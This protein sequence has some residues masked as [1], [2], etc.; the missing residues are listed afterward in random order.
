MSDLNPTANIVFPSMKVRSCHILSSRPLVDGDECGVSRSGSSSP[1]VIG[2][3]NRRKSFNIMS[4][5]DIGASH[6]NLS[7][8]NCTYM[9][10]MLNYPSLSMRFP[11]ADSKE[12]HTCTG[13]STRTW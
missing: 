12:K 2:S 11:T 13:S 6:I 7:S 10:S 4:Y 5:V 1:F 3:D 9:L 8:D